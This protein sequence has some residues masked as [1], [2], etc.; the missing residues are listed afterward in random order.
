MTFRF[1]TRWLPVLAVMLTAST[2]GAQASALPGI[3]VSPS[4]QV[5]A[6]PADMANFFGFSV[7]GLVSGNTAATPVTT[8]LSLFVAA[9]IAPDGSFT[10]GDLAVADGAAAWLNGSLSQIAFTENTAGDDTIELLFTTL[11]GAAAGEFGNLSVLTL[12][13]EFGPTPFAASAPL[14]TSG[15]FGTAQLNPASSAAIPLPAGAV[16]LL[17]ALGALGLAARRRPA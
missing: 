2:G 17:G 13:G 7:F 10:S 1:L 8:G 3:T 11:N 4:P 15:V 12:M 5:D 6:D 16:L 9:D 14:A